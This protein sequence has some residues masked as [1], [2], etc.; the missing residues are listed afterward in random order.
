MH[1]EQPLHFTVKQER[2]RRKPTAKKGTVKRKGGGTKIEVRVKGREGKGERDGEG[3]GNR[4]AEGKEKERR[5]KSADCPAMC[6]HTKTLLDLFY[7]MYMSILL[8]VC[9]STMHIPGA[10]RSDPL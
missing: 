7:C 9:S 2:A 5:K 3:K 6:A 1:S 8:H 10:C 4:D